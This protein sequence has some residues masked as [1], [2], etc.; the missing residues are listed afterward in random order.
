MIRFVLDT[1][2]LSLFRRG[3][4]HSVERLQ[5]I[6]RSEIA[7]TVISVEEQFSG[8]YNLLS[9]RREVSRL[10]AVYE[11][12]AE[13]ATFF[14]GFTVMNFSESA[15]A[16]YAELQAQKLNIGKQDLRIAS[17]ALEANATVVTRNRRDFE[18]VPGL[19][20]TDWSVAQA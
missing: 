1:D 3:N 8:W 9:Q 17:I 13:T 6:P 10:A 5:T 12:L 18:R 19:Q 16:R 14:C 15:I 11:R 7:V 2:S 20:I 4:P